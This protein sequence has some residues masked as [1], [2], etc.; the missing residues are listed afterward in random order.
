MALIRLLDDVMQAR[1][2]K[3]NSEEENSDVDERDEMTYDEEDVSSSLDDDKPSSGAEMETCQER[4]VEM[5]EEFQQQIM[6]EIAD[7]KTAIQVLQAEEKLF[8]AKT[9]R[10]HV[11]YYVFPQFPKASVIKV[12]R[13]SRLH[14]VSACRCQEGTTLRAYHQTPGYVQL[15][16]KLNELSP[17]CAGSAYDKSKLA[18]WMRGFRHQ[19]R[20]QVT[21]T[22]S[23]WPHNCTWSD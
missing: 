13:A 14:F 16:S 6:K 2:R 9:V 3:A 12:S 18:E 23:M 21:P 1:K 19:V 4:I 20:I 8:D 22:C 5:L 7:I 11:L 10:Q 15:S 17:V